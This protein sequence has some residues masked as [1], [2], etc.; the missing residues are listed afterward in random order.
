MSRPDVSAVSWGVTDCY[1]SLGYRELG[2]RNLLDSINSTFG[3]QGPV[4]N[5]SHHDHES[6]D[7]CPSDPPLSPGNSPQGCTTYRHGLLLSFPPVYHPGAES[8]QEEDIRSPAYRA[9]TPPAARPRFDVRADWIRNTGPRLRTSGSPPPRNPYQTPHLHTQLPPPLRDPYLVPDPCHP[10]PWARHT[11][12]PPSA[13]RIP[14]DDIHQYARTSEFARQRMEHE[15]RH[16]LQGQRIDS[17]ANQIWYQKELISSL[18][19]EMLENRTE[20]A[21][22]EARSATRVTI[23]VLVLVLIYILVES[24]LRR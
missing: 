12:A 14:I 24:Y 7:V 13:M 23:A 20:A 11:M 18:K 16:D 2:R 19:K 3:P 4:H 5:D 10:N 15:I 17:L 1:Q 8:D 21:R 6:N 9:P 22:T